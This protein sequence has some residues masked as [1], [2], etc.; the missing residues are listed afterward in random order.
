MSLVD[1]LKRSGVLK[2]PRIIQAF[3]KIHRADFMPEGMGSLS[4]IDEPFLIGEGQTISQPTTVAIMLE[5]LQ[6]EP[7]DKVLDV[8]YGSGWQTALLASM[9]G[10]RGTVYGVERL[11][12]L[13]AFGK[14]NISKYPFLLEKRVRLYCRDG[15]KGLP[16]VAK[17]EKGFDCIIAAASGTRVPQAFRDQLKVGGR[18][19]LP[20]RESLWLFVKKKDGS[21]ASKEKPG[22]L[23]VP[24]VEDTIRRKKK[25]FPSVSNAVGGI[26]CAV[27]MS[28]AA[29]VSFFS[30]PPLKTP[31]PREVTIPHNVSAREAA[32]LLASAG[33]IRSEQF[34]SIL[35][36]LKGVAERV[37][38]GTY[39]F[40]NPL[41]VP[42]IAAM[43]SDPATQ[44]I[45]TLRVPEG[46]SLR[47]LGLL[48]EEQGFFMRKDL[49]T[50][51]GTPAIDYQKDTSESLPDFSGFAEQFPFLASRPAHATLEGYLLPDTYEFF[52]AVTPAET[53]F[54]MLKNFQTKLAKEGLFEEIE[55]QK[56]D[57]YEVV[58]VASLLERE[59]MTYEDKRIIAG[60]IKNRVKR[61]MPLQLDASLMYVTG[62]GS[63]LL[64]KDDLTLDSPYNTYKYK[65][66]P[67][68]PIANP[69][70]ESLKAALFPATT[71]YLY[72]L[73]DKNY[74]IHYS[75]TFEEHKANKARYIF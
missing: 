65:G 75:E 4:D 45:I 48:F 71:S 13:C 52:D 34:F 40:E 58:I 61:D 36:L 22:F 43:I 50:I 53:V 60:I 5:L 27:I 56:R 2:T 38:A 10:P 47:G 26:L 7:G 28:T 46:T 59:A 37:Q 6:P 64:T 14:E 29:L 19:V 32:S 51:T 9:V 69:G 12:K 63:L 41:W 57:L 39:F 16:H 67:S 68:G 35:L 33:I 24:L 15:S 3:E 70:I 66:L 54:A 42:A 23:F 62:R 44:K 49:W 1:D 18:L 72:Y 21:F 25:H 55:K 8:G 20:I 30:S 73:S 11:K 74:R 17:K 31:Y